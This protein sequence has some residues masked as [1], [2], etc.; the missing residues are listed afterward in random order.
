[1]NISGIGYR[2]ELSGTSFQ[3]P[4]TSTLRKDVELE[5]ARHLCCE[6]STSGQSGDLETVSRCMLG[7]GGCTDCCTGESI[8]IYCI[9]IEYIMLSC[10]GLDLGQIGAIS[11]IPLETDQTRLLCA[12]GCFNFFKLRNYLW[13][14]SAVWEWSRTWYSFRRLLGKRPP[15][16]QDEWIT[17]EMVWL[18][19]PI[20]VLDRDLSRDLSDL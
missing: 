10:F 5:A 17:P 1:M 14:E 11:N 3:H 9:L 20:Y 19:L 18:S 8:R 4:L 12:N 15:C 16:V 13:G 2:T 6:A 7:P